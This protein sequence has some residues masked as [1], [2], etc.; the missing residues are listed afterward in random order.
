MP[1]T[2]SRRGHAVKAP[3]HG[4]APSSPEAVRR[5]ALP[6]LRPD[7]RSR[8]ADQSRSGRGTGRAFT[9]T[10]AATTRRSAMT[11]RKGPA[12][13]AR[14]RQAGRPGP[15]RW[16]RRAQ[17]EVADPHGCN[18]HRCRTALAASPTCR[19]RA[20]P[21]GCPTR[22]PRRY[23]TCDWNGSHARGS[24]AV[25]SDPA[26]PTCAPARFPKCG[27]KR[28]RSASGRSAREPASAQQKPA[29][30]IRPRTHAPTAGDRRSAAF[31]PTRARSRS[32]RGPPRPVRHCI[33]PAWRAGCRGRPRSWCGRAH[34][35]RR[36]RG[37]V[38]A[39]DSG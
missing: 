26:A 2:L 21:T 5:G 4:F 3:G 13:E 11:G 30:Q 24:R 20:E 16:H 8:A 34:R 28:P 32:P 36:R 12:P 38:R 17:R 25:G 10:S 33:A 39:R 29:Q 27:R 31:M 22:P 7:P 35:S 9:M 6:A 15:L 14:H 37:R 1:T 23:R 18:G 19:L